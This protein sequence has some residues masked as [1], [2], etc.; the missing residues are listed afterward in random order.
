MAN[1]NVSTAQLDS[2]AETIAEGVARGIAATSPKKLTFG[3]YT[4]R[5]AQRNPKPKLTR[6]MF[7]N[8]YPVD[9]EVLSAKEIEA[10][11]RITHSGRYLDR[12]VEVIVNDDG[13]DGEVVQIRY[14][15]K[16]PDQ[17]FENKSHFLNIGDLAGKIADAQEA[18]VLDDATRPAK[19]R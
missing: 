9:A 10:L 3:Q 1:D 12:R 11:N 14:A 6:K 15:N 7:Q 8:G 17:R 4:K 16:T 13:G 18:E 2:M 5:E 19:R